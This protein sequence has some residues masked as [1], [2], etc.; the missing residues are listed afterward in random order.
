MSEIGSISISVGGENGMKL[1]SLHHG[2][3]TA[4]V[5]E[6]TAQ[7]GRNEVVT[8]QVPEWFKIA[9]RY[10][11]LVPLIML[12]VALISASVVTSC[13]KDDIV[14][15]EEGCKCQE[16]RDWPSFC[17]LIF[18]LNLVV[19][20][21]YLGEKSSGNAINELKRLSAPTCRVKRDGEWQTLPKAEL[22]P[23]DIVALVI[24]ASVPADG[25]L[26]GDGPPEK[27]APLKID[28][29]SVTGE[30]LP[31]TKHVG[32]SVLT[33]TTVLSGELEM[34][35]TLTGE[36]SSMGEALKLIGEVGEKG[37]KLK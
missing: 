17:L 19:W 13:H 27:F 24:G 10:L 32:D 20:C 5:E 30:P 35:V 1:T 6:K 14:E 18:E 3:T 25:L 2:L 36:R 31:E 23:G 7:F 16:I 29:A 15:T 28:A 8:E 37:G 34:Q 11:G 21:D 4:E 9:S 22:V 12:F 26:R 33:A